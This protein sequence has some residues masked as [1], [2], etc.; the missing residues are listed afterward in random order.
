MRLG[1]FL[2]RRLPFGKINDLRVLLSAWLL[3][4]S[5]SISAQDLLFNNFMGSAIYT[6]PALAGTGRD[7][8]N[9]DGGRLASLY[10]NQWAMPGHNP[11]N[12]NY[13]GY[14]QK[15]SDGYGN[16]GAYF[17]YDAA[18]KDGAYR[19]VQ[20]NAVYAYELPIVRNKLNVRYGMSVGYKHMSIS[21]EKLTYEDQIDWTRGVVRESV[22]S[23]ESIGKSNVD[24]TAGAVMYHSNWF[25]GF[26]IH[27]VQRPLYNYLGT[28]DNRL[29]RRYQWLGGYTF[30][31]EK[32]V[33]VRALSAVNLQGKNSQWNASLTA[34]VRG[35][36]ISAGWRKC[37]NTYFNTDAM[38]FSAQFS[39]KNLRVFYGF[40]Y[41]VSALRS[42]A[43][44]SHEVGLTLPFTINQYFREFPR[45]K[46][47][48]KFPY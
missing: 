16:W 46:N 21:N 10:R 47:P 5:S 45:S 13:F 37:L 35:F 32:N 19:T 23:G 40:E 14:D 48:V 30:G 8:L 34:I 15:I 27:N 29:L 12:C 33:R 20:A 39:A 25:L 17:I 22:E 11:Y 38:V 1:G 3:V 4:F 2:Y 18:G 28:E 41:T 43:P 7:T 31:M 9:R 24:L 36:E 42:Y 26:G 6:N 44:T